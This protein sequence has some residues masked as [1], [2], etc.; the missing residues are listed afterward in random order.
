M[1]VFA[2]AIYRYARRVM[3]PEEIKRAE[4]L[5]GRADQGDLG[6]RLDL[7]DLV[8]RV[9]MDPKRRPDGNKKL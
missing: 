6:A 3:T 4:R 5:A 2:Y 7:E 9:V 8:N 1:T